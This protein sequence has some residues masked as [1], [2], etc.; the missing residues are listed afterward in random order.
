M[1]FRAANLADAENLAVLATQVWL[2][3]YATQ[4]IRG[5]IS[6]YVR[7]EFTPE[8]FTEL[9]LRDKPAFLVAESDG[10]LIG[11]SQVTT[12]RATELCGVSPQAEIE[13]LYIQRAFCN[14]GLGAKFMALIVRDANQSQIKALW[15]AAWAANE[16]ALRF[17]LRHGFTDVGSTSFSLGAE[18]HENRVLVRTL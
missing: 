15:L 6:K 8:R 5:S 14:R 4:G 18:Q 10:H 3:S 13:R 9:L 17:Y 2:D 12:G 16:S 11:F 7:A 1:L